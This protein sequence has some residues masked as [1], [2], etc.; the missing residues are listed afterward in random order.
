MRWIRALA[1]LALASPVFAQEPRLD[2]LRSAVEFERGHEVLPRALEW[3]A[4]DGPLAPNGEAVALVARCLVEAGDEARAESLLEAARPTDATR[5]WIEQE[6]A[7]L[8]LRRDELDRVV[9]LL[10]PYRDHPESL[11]LMARAWS[12]AGAMDKAEP[13]CRE[14]VE[15]VPLHPEAP[16]ALHLLERAAI[17]RRDVAA[18]EAW[19]QRKERMRRW[20]DIF[21]ARRLQRLRDPEAPEPELGLAVLWLEVEQYARAEE[22]L[23]S[24]AA[25]APGFCRVWFLLGESRRLQ[26]K[27]DA[28]REAYDAGVACD[29]ADTKSRYNRALL[30]LQSG[31]LEAARADFEHIATGADGDD[32]R[33]AGAHLNLA[34]LARERG[35]DPSPH[36]ARY[37]QL[38]GREEL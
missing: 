11:L 6:R 7:R 9:Q 29:P 20:H 38:G 35:E 21:K 2:E 18:A 13:L 34:R 1:V 5:V 12:R 24:L 28:A 19:R 31:E 23:A 3:V 33:F 25:R 17:E 37:R 26:S 36:Y 4:P 14:F 8:A 22:I 10:T 32:P 15:R 30:D 16:V 27:S